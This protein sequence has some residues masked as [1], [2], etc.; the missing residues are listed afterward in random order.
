[1]FFSSRKQRPDRA[2]VAADFRQQ[3]GQLVDRAQGAGV[4]FHD[5]VDALEGQVDH[6]RRMAAITEPIL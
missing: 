4:R 1:M 5:L 6:L 3:L 2:Q